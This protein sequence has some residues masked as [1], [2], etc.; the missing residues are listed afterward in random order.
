[1]AAIMS[2]SN[3]PQDKIRPLRRENDE[4]AVEMPLPGNL[5]AEA[6]VL[7]CIMEDA[8]ELAAV[9][10]IITNPNDFS[11]GPNRA[12]YQVMLEM[13]DRG[14]PVN[15]ATVPI[16]LHRLGRLSSAE[17]M[18]YVSSLAN[19]ISSSHD[20]AYFARIVHD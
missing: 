5:D 11:H 19:R 9:R 3:T 16:E 7:G 13:A 4:H 2:N 20:A 8:H 15:V 10:Q 6:A 1:M 12:V 14:D 18:G 17:D